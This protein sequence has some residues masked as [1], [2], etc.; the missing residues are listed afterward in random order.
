MSKFRSNREI[1]VERLRKNASEIDRDFGKWFD[2]QGREANPHCFAH[3]RGHGAHGD[4]G[5][6]LQIRTARRASL[7]ISLDYSKVYVGSSAL[8]PQR[9]NSVGY[10]IGLVVH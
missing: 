5:R 8:T 4:L 2:R 7:R 3:R 6:G 1:V 10:S 9:V